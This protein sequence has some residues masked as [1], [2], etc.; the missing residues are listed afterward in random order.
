MDPYLPTHGN[1][2]YT[3]NRYEL[4]LD[5]RVASNRLS[6][7]ARLHATATRALDRLSLDLDGLRVA[8]VM[9]NGRRAARYSQREGKLNIWLESP[10][11]VGAGVVLDIQYSGRPRPTVG[12]WGEVG[13]EELTDGVIVAGQPDGAPSWFPCND[14]PSDKASFSIAVTT[15]AGYHVVANGTLTERVVMSSRERWCFEQPEPMAT[16]LATV[17]IGRYKVLETSDAPVRQLAAV[18]ERLQAVFRHDFGRQHEMMVLFE[19]LFGPY[20]FAD[21][22]VVVADDELEIP[23][24]AQ[25]L[26]VFGR[27]HLDGRRG[28]QR[29]VA[30]ELAHQWFGNSLTVRRWQDIWLH[31]GFACYAEWLWS[32]GSGG[33]SADVLA[34]RAWERLSA[35][36]QDITVGDPGAGLDVRR[37]RLQAGGLDAART[38]A[39]GRRRHAGRDPPGVDADARARHGR[40][41]RLRRRRVP[42]HRGTAA[43]AVPLLAVRA[44]PSRAAGEP[45]MVP[46]TARVTSLT[47]PSDSPQ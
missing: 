17:Q 26:S 27:N 41:R 31:E 36:P 19:R 34:R 42:P 25:G 32:E 4:D 18:P 44:G 11:G 46:A 33:P 12:T 9:V 24:E 7:R 40:H 2:G 3:V 28:Q 39:D 15:D 1:A 14:H 20:P 21:Y 47:G 23:L 45:V 37:P 38:S 43:R 13:W 16:Y 30:H 35:L 5:Y 6:A 29:L 8:K 10:V 22:T